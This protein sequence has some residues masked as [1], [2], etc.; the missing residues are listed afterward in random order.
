MAR[1]ALLFAAGALAALH[2]GALLPALLL[3]FFARPPIRAWVRPTGPARAATLL[4]VA[5][6][7][8]SGQASR[9]GP[10][11]PTRLDGPG[12]WTGRFLAPSG[13]GSVPFEVEGE[14]CGPIRV[15]TDDVHPAGLRMRVSGVFRSGSGSG[16]VLARAVVGLPDP[17]PSWGW[18][19]VRWRGALVQR[20]HARYGDR[21]PLVAALVLARREG[22]DPGVRD[23]F[24]RAGT[25]HLLAISGFHV[26][27]VAGLVLVVLR[28]MRLSRRRAAVL[29][30]IVTWAYVG[31]LGFPAAA[32]R[33]ALIL[34]V[35]ALSALRGRPTARWGGLAAA[36]LVLVATDPARLG[37][38]G[39]QL[40]FAGSAGLLAWS[41]PIAAALRRRVPRLPDEAGAAVAAGAAATLATLP[42]V[43][44]HFEQ[45]SLVGIPA[46]LVSSPLVAVALPGALFG[47]LLDPLWP[48][49]AAFLALGVDTLL[50]VLARGTE[51]VAASPFAAVEVP[52][53]WVPVAAAVAIP[54]AWLVSRRRLSGRVR[55]VVVMASGVAAVVVWPAAAAL[56]GRGTLELLVADVGQGDGLALRMPSGR[57]WVV[58]AGPP[59]RPGRRGALYEAL[60]R[61]GVVR[62]ETLVLTHPDLDHIGG[63]AELLAGFEVG[64]VIDPGRATGKEAFV[65]VLAAAA[66]A[67]VPWRSAAPGLRW[68]TDGVEIR[69]LT[70]VDTAPGGADTDTNDASVVLLV[71]YGAF[72]A[73]LTGDAPAAVER[74]LA[75][76]GLPEALEVLKVGHHGSDTSTD[77]LL[78]SRARPRLGIVSVGRGNRYG[79]PTRSVL[80]RLTSAGVEIRRTDRDGSIRV[81]ARRDGSFTVYTAP[82]R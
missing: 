72:E 24:A 18:W 38:V 60:S 2:F 46:T 56:A 39:F 20:I 47:M 3:V 43:A 9:T 79:H 59:P 37:G 77:P 61:R 55:R 33:A 66:A 64:Q 63:A 26:G 54:V 71:A 30:V 32:A 19:P 40:S 36:F 34:T 82:P 57:W 50:V 27:V 65:E 62:I 53:T 80:D 44:W 52:R 17:D 49:G 11:C 45:V 6:G 69:V 28:G 21:G 35:A 78:L 29:A 16:L 12:E 48:G 81:V 15:W 73:L 25:A 76:Q 4:V 5:A 70:P 8:V 10:S 1:V 75:R 41:R 68:N 67:G 7:I 23:A 51:A 13:A 31:L 42:V 74:A 14:P 58:D 22:I